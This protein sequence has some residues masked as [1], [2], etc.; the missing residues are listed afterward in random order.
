MVEGSGSG[1]WSIVKRVMTN[2]IQSYNDLDVYQRAYRLSV[3][4]C[5]KIVIKLPTEEKF[6][7][8]DQLRR[9]SKAIPRL[10]AEGFGKKH[11]KKGFQKYLDDASAE[12]NETVVSLCHIRDIYH[13]Y[14]NQE[15]VRRMIRE[16]EIIGK[17]IYKLKQSWDKFC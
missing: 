3:V 5:S 6:D 12:V 16:Y 15:S 4:V 14:V 9:S 1:Y 7:L 10:I 13:S 2:K 8:V 11:Q 17:Q